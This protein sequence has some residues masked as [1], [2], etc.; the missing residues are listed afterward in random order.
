M[1]KMTNNTEKTTR[2][3]TAVDIR[4]CITEDTNVGYL[5][6][7]DGKLE[8]VGFPD[9]KDSLAKVELINGVLLI[10]PNDDLHPTERLRFTDE[11]LANPII[12]DYFRQQNA[13]NCLFVRVW[14]VY[15]QCKGVFICED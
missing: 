8:L 10:T 4:K 15:T 5:A 9:L 13:I 1:N 14:N 6:L 7:R 3:E 12:I 11:T 2:T